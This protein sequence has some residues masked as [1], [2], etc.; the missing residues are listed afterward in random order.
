MKVGSTLRRGDPTRAEGLKANMPDPQGF[1]EIDEETAADDLILQ[2]FLPGK[3]T[4]GR[5]VFSLNT[6]AFHPKNS[7]LK[8][9]LAT[10]PYFR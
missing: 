5:T 8:S 6:Q 4:C 2:P 3:S 9:W 7:C 10:W 1:G